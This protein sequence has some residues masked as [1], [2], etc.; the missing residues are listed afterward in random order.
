MVANKPPGSIW[1]DRC[2]S[3]PEQKNAAKPIG[4]DCEPKKPD[5]NY[6]PC[7]TANPDT[8]DIASAGPTNAIFWQVQLKPKKWIP[9]LAVF[10]YPFGVRISCFCTPPVSAASGAGM[11]PFFLFPVT[12]LSGMSRKFPLSGGLFSG[13]GPGQTGPPAVQI[14]NLG[15]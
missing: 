4:P 9:G 1:A 5:G 10:Y 13:F 3:G 8:Y 2:F 12:S 15:G 6:R 11:H 14:P 7:R